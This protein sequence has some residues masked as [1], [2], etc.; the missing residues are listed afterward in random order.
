[1]LQS[2]RLTLRQWE[3][4]D[5]SP[6]AAMNND[7]E[8]MRYFPATATREESEKLCQ[9]L[10]QHISIHGWGWWAVEITATKEFIGTVGL[11][12]TNFDSH[13]TP[14]IEIGWRLSKPHWGKGFAPEAAKRVLQFA[15]DELQLN[16]VVSFASTINVPS[17]TVMEKLGMKRRGTFSHPNVAVDSSLNEHVLYQVD[18]YDF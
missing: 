8:V 3:D 6:F 4:R 12:Q 9:R 2:K 18:R 13:F 5:L 7:A 10:K 11:M 17:I 14:A 15:F 1:M 16:H